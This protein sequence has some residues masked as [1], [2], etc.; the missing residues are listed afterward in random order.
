LR[1]KKYAFGVFPIPASPV[2]PKWPRKPASSSARS[3]SDEDERF[4]PEA[5]HHFTQLFNCHTYYLL[6]SFAELDKILLVSCP[7]D[8]RHKCG[9]A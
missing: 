8:E 4:W 7:V 6:F 3:W 1:V 5:C 9:R 2:F